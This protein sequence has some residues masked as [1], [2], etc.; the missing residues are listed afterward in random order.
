[1]TELLQ[2]A[3]SIYRFI[4][5]MLLSKGNTCCRR[6]ALCIWCSV[7]S[8][9]Q[10]P[11]NYLSRRWR[12]TCGGHWNNY[13]TCFLFE[14]RVDYEMKKQNIYWFHTKIGAPSQFV[15][16]SQEGECRAAGNLVTVH[17]ACHGPDSCHIYK[18]ELRPCWDPNFKIP[19]DL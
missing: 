9:W 6:L 7:A 11:F 16:S 12:A 18:E 1:M 14:S 3:C 8:N 4:R 2:K 17:W 15:L 19:K 5:V 13:I 10:E